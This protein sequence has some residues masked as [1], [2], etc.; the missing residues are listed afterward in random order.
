MKE[1]EAVVAVV[2]VMEP[3][4][5]GRHFWW[6]FAQNHD[7]ALRKPKAATFPVAAQFPGEETLEEQMVSMVLKRKLGEGRDGQK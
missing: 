4:L 7:L 2:V 1:Q 6:V 5:D 3:P